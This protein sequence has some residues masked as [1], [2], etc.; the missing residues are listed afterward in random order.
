M[1]KLIGA[2]S[3]AKRIDWL[4]NGENSSGLFEHR[5]ALGSLGEIYDVIIHN[6]GETLNL[7]CDD[8]KIRIIDEILSDDK[9]TL[10]QKADVL[11]Q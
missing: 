4:L 10:Q 7:L 1:V 8:E 3:M 5:G 11:L 9:T 2:Y 6:V